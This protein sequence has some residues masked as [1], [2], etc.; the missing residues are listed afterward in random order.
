MAFGKG[1][2]QK[3]KVDRRQIL[4]DKLIDLMDSGTAPWQKPWDAG[5]V[6]APINAIT[7]KPYRGVNMQTLM[8]STPDPTDNRWCTY[9]QAEERGWQVR[10]G[11]KA[12]AYVEFLV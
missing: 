3:E 6:M 8:L 5:E 7:K 4:A 2:Q 11:E 1:K 10:K 9:K 12:R